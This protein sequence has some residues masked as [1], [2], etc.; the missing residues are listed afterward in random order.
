M[1]SVAQFTYNR[2]DRNVVLSNYMDEEGGIPEEDEDQE[3]V[4]FH[5]SNSQ[6]CI[7]PQMNDTDEGIKYILY[8]MR[9]NSFMFQG[10][11]YK[12]EFFFMYDCNNDKNCIET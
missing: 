10:M 3:E 7:R 6:E 5:H 8:V 12:C 2:G 1:V 9:S 11:S 4:A